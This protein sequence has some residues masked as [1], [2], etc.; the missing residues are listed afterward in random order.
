MH[1]FSPDHLKHRRQFVLGPRPLEEFAHWRTTSVGRSLVLQVHEDLKLT[2]VAHGGL[3]LTLLGFVIDPMAPEND[4]EQILRDLAERCPDA[5]HA[6]RRAAELA[7]RWIMIADDGSDLILFHDAC[8]LRQVYHSTWDASETWCASQPTHVAS[9]IRAGVGPAH[10][11]FL[12][13]DYVRRSQEPWFPSPTTP[14]QGVRHLTPNH[15]LDLRTRSV[16]RYWPHSPLYRMEAEEGAHLA[17]QLLRESLRAARRRFRLAIPLTAGMDSRTML[18]ASR[19][20]EDTCHYTLRWPGLDPHAPD[21]NTPRNVLRRLGRRH[22]F[23]ECPAS[24]SKGF[25]EV[26]KESSVL[27]HRTLGPLAE[28]LLPVFP[29]GFVQIPGQCSEIVRDSFGVTHRSLADADTLARLMGMRGN[30]FAIDH[31]DL[32]LDQVRPI[33]AMTGHREW[34]LFFMEQ[35]F[36]VRA[37]QNQAHWDLVHD[38]F[39]PFNHRGVLTALMGVDPIHRQGPDYAANRRVIEILWPDATR[40]PFNAAQKSLSAR[41]FEICLKMRDSCVRE[42]ISKGVRKLQ[43]QVVQR[44]NG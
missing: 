26:F 18:A 40:E 4:D 12:A 35:E 17:A 10:R 42:T 16:R 3:R 8:G 24:M 39:T 25:E 30:P 22:H 20:I 27:P 31:F 7:G 33:T 13:S 14:W 21:L 9:A 44:S 2:Q 11:E 23:I 38:A 5:Q 6:P 15:C 41:S 29:E 43:A 34:D 36:G 28:G 37:A 1:S 19:G 32:W